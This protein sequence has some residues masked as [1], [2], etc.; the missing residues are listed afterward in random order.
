MDA[1]RSRCNSF[2]FLHRFIADFQGG[3]RQ[4]YA[5][6]A[7]NRMFI[8][9]RKSDGFA[10]LQHHIAFQHIGHQTGEKIAYLGRLGI[11]IEHFH[12]LFSEH[13]HAVGI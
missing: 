4:R 10:V 2:S 9:R 3:P 8:L 6:D 1:P 11:G 5:G 12:F 7:G 13:I